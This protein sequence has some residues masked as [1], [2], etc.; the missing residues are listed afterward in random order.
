M[1]Q[2][3]LNITV[4]PEGS[5]EVLQLKTIKN[6]A[7][8]WN[9]WQ[10]YPNANRMVTRLKLYL[11][12]IGWL[13]AGK[14]FRMGLSMIAGIWVARYLGA[15]MF[16]ILSF[17]MAVALLF[18]PMAMF[19]LEGICVREL[20][21]AP[22]KKDEILGSA[23]LLSLGAGVL[24]M[25]AALGLI[26]ILHPDKQLY[27]LIVAIA[28]TG[29][30]FFSFEIFEYWFQAKVRSKATV[31]S[32]TI[33]LCMG[34]V[35][36]I[37]GIFFNAGIFYFAWINTIESILMGISL[38]IAYRLS[39]NT[40]MALKIRWQ[41]M[42]KLFSDAWPLALSGMAAT[43]YL[44]IDK[45]MIGQ[46]MDAT[47]VG[48]YTAAT[49]LAE[50]WYFL[51]ICIMTSLYP[52]VVKAI[53]NRS[54]VQDIRMQ[55]MYNM[56]VLLGYVTIII[57]AVFAEPLIVFLFGPE[58]EPASQILVLYIWSGLFVN[59]AMVKAAWLKA[60]NFT[61]IQFVS[62]LAGAVI[63]V[64]LNL[65]FIKHYGV[66]GAAWATIISYAVEGYF[67]LFVFP[68][69]RKQAKMITKAMYKPIVRIN[70]IL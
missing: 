14:I 48:I 55:Q 29:L 68:Q 20:I 70:K 31:L 69:T 8:L 38:L 3:K 64:G 54:K 23:F 28:G 6:F 60:M 33:V 15:Q 65:C 2:K 53:K 18:R 22:D 1:K 26:H 37:T 19:Q 9:R 34:A 13:F 4:S 10:N 51:P 32:R 61:K 25:M 7:P 45:I 42:N 52:A 40:L 62:T 49:R 5:L 57:T 59:I 36:K 30:V 43:I 44:R 39:G 11:T 21:S 46:I 17:C 47:Q 56:M 63:N 41:W 66:I 50:A 35:L 16:G 27:I 58:Y 12:N 67:I 24:A